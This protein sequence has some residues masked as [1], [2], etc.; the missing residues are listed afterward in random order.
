MCPV[1]ALSLC[2]PQTEV[3]TVSSAHC[4]CRCQQLFP[5]LCSDADSC[6]SLLCPSQPIT[7]PKPLPPLPYYGVMLQGSQGCLDSQCAL[8]AELWWSGLHQRS[9]LFLMCCLSNCQQGP[10]P[11]PGFS[12]GLGNLCIQGLVSPLVM[13]TTGPVLH[14]DMK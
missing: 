10:L 14:C 13:A 7:P 3:L 6:A 1:Q 9:G 4:L 12:W 11:H 2:Q 8:G 5:L